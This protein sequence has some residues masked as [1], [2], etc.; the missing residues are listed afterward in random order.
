MCPKS[1]AFAFIL[2][3]QRSSRYLLSSTPFCSRNRHV[4]SFPSLPEKYP[5]L[6]EESLRVAFIPCDESALLLPF[7]LHP[8]IPDLFSPL[9]VTHEPMDWLYCYKTQ[10]SGVVDLDWHWGMRLNQQIMCWDDLPG[11]C[12]IKHS[13]FRICC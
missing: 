13:N 7:P 3:G 1:Y 9:S 12:I 10:R 5:M 6:C 2:L 11:V 4:W 8:V